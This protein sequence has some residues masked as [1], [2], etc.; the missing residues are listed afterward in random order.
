MRN[1]TLTVT[2]LNETVRAMLENEPLLDGVRLKGEISNFKRHSSGHLYFSLKDEGGVIR[3]VMFR[4]YAQ[5]LSILP[6]DGMKVVLAGRVSLYVR[7]GQYQFYAQELQ[8]DGEGALYAEFERRKARMLA[9]GLFDAQLKK[10]LPPHPR[11]VAVITSPTG[12]AVQDVLRVATRRNP[13]VSLMVV[14]VAVQGVSAADEIAA[15][16]Q[17]V[18]EMD[19]IDIII[20]GRGGGSIEELWAFNE[21]AVVYAIAACPIPI[22]SAVGHETD[23]TLADFVADVRAAT[24]SMA[25]ELA[26][27]EQLALSTTVLQLRTRLLRAVQNR[28]KR[29]QQRFLSLRQS[30]VLRRPMDALQ[31]LMQTL[32][33]LSSRL[34][35]AGKARMQA[36]MAT[37]AALDARIRARDPLAALNSG[38]AYITHEGSAVRDASQLSPGDRLQLQFKTGS[39]TA[40][41]QQV[42]P[43][44]NK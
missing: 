41:V 32:D 23:F 42:L 15:A 37:H 9:E 3:C 4:T 33:G 2:E 25:A 12:A 20:T 40:D 5:R 1:L 16:I 19:G 7:D 27:P 39:A 36:A 31:P 43:H 26:V 29:D 6:R 22:I 28:F 24:P 13:S 34:S 21:E 8:Q 14:P 10:P 35:Y 11:K 30:R 44:Q 17:R 18:G 38:F